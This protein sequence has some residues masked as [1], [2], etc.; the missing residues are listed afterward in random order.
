ML[1][2]YLGKIQV[3]KRKASLSH[4]GSHISEVLSFIVLIQGAAQKS[5]GLD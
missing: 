4:L 3:S 5:D 2:H 1:A